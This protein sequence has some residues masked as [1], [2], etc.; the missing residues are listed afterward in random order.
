MHNT[1]HKYPLSQYILLTLPS[2]DYLYV[3]VTEERT[4]GI[5]LSAALRTLI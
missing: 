1:M 3:Y 5:G 4:H 2:L